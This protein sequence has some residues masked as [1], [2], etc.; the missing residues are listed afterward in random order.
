MNL[1]KAEIGDKKDIQE[2]VSVLNFGMD[3]FVWGQDDFIEKQIN[4]GEYFIEEVDGIMAGIIS[5]RRREKGM[6]IETLAVVQGFRRKGIGANLIKFAQDF[7]K[8]AGV[9]TLCACAF[10]EYKSEDFYLGLGFVLSKDLG[11]YSGRKF[12]RFEKK[13]A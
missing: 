3:D 11:E 6:Y 12:Y 13:I 5:L 2:I 1:R 9:D 10:P 8:Q 7:A 4:K